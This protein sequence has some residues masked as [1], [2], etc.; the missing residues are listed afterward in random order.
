MTVSIIVPVYNTEAFLAKALDSAINQTYKD[1]EILC[2]NDGSTDNSLQILNDY[3]QKDERIKVF[4]Q[5]NA[6]VGAVKGLGI[7]NA[8]GKYIMF[9][10]SD[11]FYEPDM[12]ECMVRAIE[13]HDV[14]FVM[15]DCNVTGPASGSRNVKYCRLNMFG[16]IKIEPEIIPEISVILPVKIFKKELCDK[17]AI[18][19]P[20]LA[21]H[22]D[23][24]F[25]YQYFSVAK[26]AFGLNK[27]LYNYVMRDNSLIGTM[28][29]DHK[30][31]GWLSLKF[32]AEFLR[33]NELMAKH[34]NAFSGYLLQ[35]T[36]YQW[37][38]LDKD[39]QNAALD[40]IL[41]IFNE[42]E[43]KLITNKSPFFEAMRREDKKAMAVLLNDK[44]KYTFAQRLFSIK[45]NAYHT[46]VSVLGIKIKIKYL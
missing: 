21:R 42:D 39:E 9:L 26:T 29:A 6:G 35:R 2:I 33:V 20:N 34:I 44:L 19:F 1:I 5:E 23:F 27:K 3:A 38:L 37:G 7:K 28:R 40:L 43:L 18:R 22:E 14:D 10:D 45:K 36:K 16:R 46:V 11:D 41:K 32:A 31:D 17:Y 15:C 13:E 4:S 24:A 30:L 12:C 8:S 25:A